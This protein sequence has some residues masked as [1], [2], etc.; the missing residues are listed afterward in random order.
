MGT[1]SLNSTALSDMTNIVEDVTIDAKN[2][3]GIGNQDETEYINS[4]WSKWWGYFNAIPDLKSAIIMKAIWNVGK[5]YTTDP[6][7]QVI[8][9][10]LSG[11]GKDTFDDILFNMEIIKRVS[12]DSFAEIIKDEETGILLNLKP[13]D[14]AAIKI[15]VDRKGII[16]RYEQ[17]SKTGTRG[18]VLHKFKPEDIFHLSNN[19]LADQIHG[20]SDIEVMEQTIL[21][22]NESFVDIKK[23]MHHQGKPFIIWKL[24]TDD[25]VKINEFVG[26]INKAR[27]LGEDTFIPDDDDAINFEV[28]QVNPSEMV[29]RWRDDIRNKFYRAIGMPLVIFGQAG[30]T[31]SGGKIEYLAHEQVFEKDQRY[32]EKQIWN[33]LFLRINLL[34]PTSLLDNLQTDQSKDANQGM[35]IQPQ[36]MTAGKG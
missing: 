33:Q 5:G 4:N 32:L 7:T 12:G 24:G 21:A 29:L 2:T 20:I 9:E 18:E 14:P 8:L 28:V 31:E 23:L 27:N 16:K 19:R 15:I 22:E 11:W 6:G 25:P 36:D 3:D 1:L 30:S 35:E 17:I 26:K 13:L 10:H 34:P